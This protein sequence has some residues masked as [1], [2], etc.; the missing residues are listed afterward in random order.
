MH[1]CPS[2]QPKCKVL[3]HWQT[4]H[5]H[6]PVL[7]FATLILPKGLLELIYIPMRPDE[8]AATQ[9]CRLWGCSPDREIGREFD[10][11]A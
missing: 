11:E 4:P 7:H 10:C 2:Q 5:N 8:S 9:E 3:G 1:L 6:E